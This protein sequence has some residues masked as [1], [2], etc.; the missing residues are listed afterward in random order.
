MITG[1]GVALNLMIHGDWYGILSLFVGALFI[2]SLALCLGVWTDSSKLFEFIYTMLWYIG[3]LN[4]IVILDFMGSLPESVDAGV[5]QFYLV[6]SIILIG[7]AFL[8]RK[9]QIQ[10]G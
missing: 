5:W 2:P 1:S 4:Q 6:F 8:G 10:R 7:L 9:W 3:P